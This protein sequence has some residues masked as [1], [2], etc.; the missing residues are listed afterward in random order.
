MQKKCNKS[1]RGRARY[2]AVLATLAVM[3]GAPA[4][5]RQAEASFGTPAAFVMDATAE[6][7]FNHPGPTIR[8]SGTLTLG[9]IAGEV[10]LQNN[11]KGTHKSDAEPVL[12]E[13]VLKTEN[14]EYIEVAKQPPLNGERL[15]H[16]TFQVL[17]H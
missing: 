17:H 2:V 11:A 4:S 6:G 16:E 10:Y 15:F 14:G 8:L 12:L 9:T 13:V 5:A 3:A 1:A 7:C